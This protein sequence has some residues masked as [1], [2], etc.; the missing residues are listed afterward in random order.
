MSEW[1]VGCLRD[2]LRPVA[3]GMSA[4]KNGEESRATESFVATLDPI[5]HSSS[6]FLS[7]SRLTQWMMA[8]P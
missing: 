2:P 8:G 3:D 4:E 1:V 7:G 5:L 6:S